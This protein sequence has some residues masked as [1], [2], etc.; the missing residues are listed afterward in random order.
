M[1]KDKR[2]RLSDVGFCLTV[3]ST[4]A[5][6]RLKNLDRYK[7]VANG[8][9]AVIEVAKI[10]PYGVKG[11]Y[12]CSV[13]TGV[14]FDLDG[15]C[16]SSGQIR[17]VGK[18]DEPVRPLAAPVVTAPIVNPPAKAARGKGE[19]RKFNTT[20]SPNHGSTGK[21]THGP[22]SLPVDGVAA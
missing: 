18:T 13:K 16:M 21:A 14:L 15:N 6:K 19:N 5:V 8:E 17:L 7:M 2:W 11:E 22:A 9:E 10:A 20:I 3:N 1:N 12:L 4:E